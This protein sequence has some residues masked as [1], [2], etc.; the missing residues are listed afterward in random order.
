MKGSVKQILIVRIDLNMRKVKIAAQC[1]HASLGAILKQMRREYIPHEFASLNKIKLSIDYFVQ[2]EYQDDLAYWLEHDFTKI[3]VYVNSE[4]ELLELEQKAKDANLINCLI[5]D[6]GK[7]EFNNV[8]T[9][10][11]LAIGPAAEGHLAPIT[12]HLPLL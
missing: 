4:E 5:V 9:I 2:P 8:P 7:T 6:N 11:V 3:C 1:A 10:T 12:G